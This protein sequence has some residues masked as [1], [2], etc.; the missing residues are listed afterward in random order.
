M[1][2]GGEVLGPDER[3]GVAE[4]LKAV[5]IYP[6]GQLGIDALTGSLEIGKYADL[7]L[8]DQDPSVADPN[9]IGAIRV[10]ETWL[11]GERR[12]SAAG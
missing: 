2:D 9:A 10:L 12:Y 4:A 11:G 8:L 6:A 3:I 5:T 1:R 7:A